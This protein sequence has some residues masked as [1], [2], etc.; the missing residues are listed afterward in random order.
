MLLEA[1]PS[2]MLDRLVY[3]FCFAVCNISLQRCVFAYSCNTL[4]VLSSTHGHIDYAS[5]PDVD[6]A[7]VKLLVHVR[8]RSNVWC[9]TT[10][11]RTHVC[12]SFLGCVEA[13]CVAKD[14]NFDRSALSRRFSGLRSRCAMPISCMYPRR[15]IS[16]LK[17]QSAL[18]ARVGQQR[19]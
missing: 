8:F 6:C 5:R 1:C 7:R 18:L 10:G 9:R 17:K 4:Q 3:S 14:S 11:P 19:E 16:C 2:Q 13:L 12:I 15:R